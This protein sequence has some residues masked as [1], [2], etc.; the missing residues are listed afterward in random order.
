MDDSYLEEPFGI[1]LELE[2]DTRVFNLHGR[3]PASMLLFFLMD[4]SEGGLLNKLQEEVSFDNLLTGYH[5][6][7][8]EPE[9]D[10]DDGSTEEE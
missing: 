10:V 6:N 1:T 8:K 2:P 5:T 9:G 7:G 3:A 4:A